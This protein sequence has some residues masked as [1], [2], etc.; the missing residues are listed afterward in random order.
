MGGGRDR[1]GYMGE[2]MGRWILRIVYV[3]F[4]I[5]TVVTILSVVGLLSQVKMSHLSII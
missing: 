5:P 4:L 3:S 1:S 2:W